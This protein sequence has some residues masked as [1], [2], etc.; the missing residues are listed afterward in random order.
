V[1]V[2]TKQELMLLMVGGVFVAEA[3]SVIFQVG[4]FKMT[5]QSTGTGRRLFSHDTAA[6][7]F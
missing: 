4:F 3:M 1:A 5:K 7:P 6:P 2:L